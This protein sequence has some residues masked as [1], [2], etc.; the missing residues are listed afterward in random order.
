MPRL[1]VGK[2][3]LQTVNPI[4]SQ[5]WHPTK[6]EHLRPDD[7]AQFA[8]KKVWWRGACGHEWEALVSKRSMGQNC[9]YCNHQRVLPGFNDLQSQYPNIAK[10]WN[11]SKNPSLLPKFITPRS[12][13][14]V[15]WMDNLGHEWE[16]TPD[17]RTSRN[18]KC[19]FCSGVQYLEGFNGLEITHPHLAKE[20]SPK[21]SLHYNDPAIRSVS[22]IL[23]VGDCG[24]EWEEKLTNRKSGA[25]CPVCFKRIPKHVAGSFVYE[26]PELLKEWDHDKN[27]NIFPDKITSG[28]P[29][30]VW[31]LGLCNH[32]WYAAISKRVSGTGC[33]FCSGHKVKQ[34]FNDLATK[35]TKLADEWHPYLNLGLQVTELSANSHKKVWWLGDCGHEWE[36]TINHRNNGSGCSIC[37][38]KK[39]LIG[40]ND[41]ASR[42]PGIALEWHVS[43]NGK[44]TPYNV[45]HH[46]GKKVWWQCLIDPEHHWKTAVSNRSNGKGCPLCVTYRNE[47]EFRSFFTEATSLEFVDGRIAGERELFKRDKIQI[48][49]INH[50]SSVIIEYDGHFSHG[51]NKLYKTTLEHCLARDTD[52][53]SALLKAGY[54]VVRI[55]ETPLQFFELEHEKLFQVAFKDMDDKLPVVMAAVEAL[56]AMGVDINIHKR[57][58]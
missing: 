16:A 3:D 15:W 10:E 52:T 25:R 39:I 2:N 17:K 37:S 28:S 19:P 55:R 53:T 9:P 4:L 47:S 8:N 32:S 51:G 41:L 44:T 50:E 56:Q 46:S 31:W 34:G 22:V 23:W 13:K 54:K 33:P 12:N 11:Y 36:A 29:K 35:N 49:M 1:I 57:K 20:W 58:G 7:I 24:H 38:G 27:Q 26:Y 45:T 30:K 42:F 48:D 43:K 21:N 6:N 18:Q 5:E 40:F 14:K